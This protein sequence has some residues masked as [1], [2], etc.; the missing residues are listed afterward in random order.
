MFWLFALSLP[1]F[2][3]PSAPRARPAPTLSRLSVSLCISRSG[4]YAYR[5]C[6]ADQPLTEDCFQAHHLAFE[7]GSQVL[8][9]SNGSLS[10]PMKSS[11]VYVQEGT[12][13]PGSMWA[14]NPLPRIWDSKKGLH[15]PDACPAGGP[16]GPQ[17][18]SG[19]LAFQP[20]CPWDTGIEPCHE[21]KAEG[22]GLLG[23]CDG[24]GMGFC[25][26]DW[27]V[28]LIQDTVLIP[29][30]LKAGDYVLSWRWD[31]EETAQVS[32]G[33]AGERR[34]RAG[35]GEKAFRILG[36]RCWCVARCYSLFCV[37]RQLCNSIPRLRKLF[38]PQIS[39]FVRVCRFG[40]I[41]PTSRLRWS[42]YVAS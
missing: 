4:G 13:P 38:L 40:T 7:P 25:S 9:W 39:L 20:P 33:R 31:C 37:T 15:N 26:S 36:E 14:R 10:W 6:P 3:A 22:G 18:S 19:C 1:C 11:A 5:L 34:R 27:V 2:G 23:R 12:Y 32:G 21:K 41:A 17:G 29:A 30:D 8:V 28:G 16:R 42:K 24:N 35:E